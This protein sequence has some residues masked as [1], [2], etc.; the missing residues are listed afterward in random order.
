LNF[1]FCPDKTH[2]HSATLEISST[3]E[4]GNFFIDAIIPCDTD[5]VDEFFNILFNECADN[6]IS[7]KTAELYLADKELSYIK[8]Y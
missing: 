7:L 8:I 1:G 3:D 2:S 6:K 4:I 5:S